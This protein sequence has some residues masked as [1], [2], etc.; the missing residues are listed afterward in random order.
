M[1]NHCDVASDRLAKL[2]PD[3]SIFL[4]Q[5]TALKCENSVMK[6]A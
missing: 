3:A 6:Q 4:A 2:K 5:A 1:C